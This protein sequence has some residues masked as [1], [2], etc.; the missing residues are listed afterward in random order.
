MGKVSA[1]ETTLWGAVLLSACLHALWNVFAKK[2]PYKAAFLWWITFWG[3]VPLIPLAIWLE[4]GEW[5]N[6]GESDWNV[7]LDVAVYPALS[8]V[9]HAAY[10][11]ALAQAYRKVPFG[12]AYP[13]SRGMAQVF[14]VGAGIWIFAERPSAGALAGVGCILVGLQGLAG[15]ATLAEGAGLLTKSPWPW[16]VAVCICAYTSIDHQTVQVVPPLTT[17]LIS[18]I[19]Q[20]ALLASFQLKEFSQIPSAARPR[21]MLQTLGL[22]VISTG[23]YCLF[24]W[25]QS[26]GA[27]VSLVGPLRESSILVGLLL[28]IWLLGERWSGRQVIAALILMLGIGLIRMG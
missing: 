17:C 9:S 11:Y 13:L 2:S 8:V 22:G 27:D 7:A 21:F 20:C 23:G 14:V 15:G 3:Q 4:W 28:S 12:L 25:A 6:F 16:A 1:L 18:N 26:K 24:L 19:G 5:G 10:M